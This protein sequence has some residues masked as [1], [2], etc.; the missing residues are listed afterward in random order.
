MS[1]R[2]ASESNGCT[3][4]TRP[5]AS[6]TAGAEDLSLAR[7]L[8]RPLRQ[9]PAAGARPAVA[10]RAGTR[11]ALRIRRNR[12]GLFLQ[13][14]FPDGVRFRG[15]LRARRAARYRRFPR[16]GPCERHAVP[17]EPPP[18]ASMSARPPRLRAAEQLRRRIDRNRFRSRL[19]SASIRLYGFGRRPPDVRRFRA[20][21][22]R[23]GS[24][25]RWS[26]WPGNTRSP[27]R[28]SRST[29]TNPS[30]WHAR[31][32]SISP[33]NPYRRSSNPPPARA[34]LRRRP[35]PGFRRRDTRAAAASRCG[36]TSAIGRSS[37]S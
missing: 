11:P 18:Q 14:R 13:L 15:L 7:A 3:R 26:A 37:R 17:T 35:F 23:R 20:R 30:R 4:S 22:R 32:R 25:V 31:S 27:P 16:R 9:R 29:R 24:S 21:L 5:D 28:R 34:A 1:R 33:S 10:G 12:A 8:G 2:P 36:R 19:R 6:C